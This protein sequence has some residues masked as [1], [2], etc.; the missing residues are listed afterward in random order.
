MF[1]KIKSA[2]KQ[3]AQIAVEKVENELSKSSGKEKKSAA[4]KYILSNLPISPLLKPVIE[5]FLSHFIDD[6]V[7]LAVTYMKLK[8]KKKQEG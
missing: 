5:I 4:I 1:K 2:I 6:T 7:E 8:Q 3:L